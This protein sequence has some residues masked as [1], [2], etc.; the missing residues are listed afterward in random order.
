M[1]NTVGWLLVQL[2]VGTLDQLSQHLSKRE[3][4]VSQS[5]ERLEKSIK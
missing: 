1:S 5:L 4:L 3:F 2:P